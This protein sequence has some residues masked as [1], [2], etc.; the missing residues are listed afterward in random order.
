M[1]ERERERERESRAADSREGRARER[2]RHAISLQPDYTILGHAI[3][4]IRQMPGQR[5]ANDKVAR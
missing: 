5:D 4:H 2:A 1:C 3:D